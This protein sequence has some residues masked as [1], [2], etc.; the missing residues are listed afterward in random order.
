M[1]LPP[2]PSDKAA[3]RRTLLDRRQRISDGDRLRWNAAIE[4]RLE[5]WLA[6]HTLTALGVY[7]PIRSEPELLGLYAKLVARGV[8]LSLPI[9]VGKDQPLR[10]TAWMPGDKMVRD[11]FGVPV[12]AQ[13]SFVPMPEVLLVPCVG[14]NAQGFR[15]GYGGGFYDRT[16]A[17][18]PKPV[19]IGIAYACQ[20]AAFE[21]GVHDISMDVI[22]TES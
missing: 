22:I 10:F 7:L 16:L 15:L 9:V 20:E 18:T 17:Q 8:K 4:S 5:Q 2:S 14:F 21:V 12:P 19:A 6:S 13:T 11:A 3:L 1:S